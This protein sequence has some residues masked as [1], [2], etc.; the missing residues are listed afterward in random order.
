MDDDAGFSILFPGRVTSAERYWVTSGEQRSREL[1]RP[2]VWQMQSFNTPVPR[3][4][5]S[6]LRPYRG[7]ARYRYADS[8][9][10]AGRDREIN[11]CM[12]ALEEGPETLFILH[13]K[14][15]CGKSSFSGAERESM[16]PQLPNT[17]RLPPV[18]A[19]SAFQIQN[20]P[21]AAHQK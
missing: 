16:F 19:Q 2:D 14:S 7:L 8:R 10:F 18:L 11:Q 1:L 12:D 3:T 21:F 13:G 4:T 15:G 5:M 20:C 6:A 17:R 9:L